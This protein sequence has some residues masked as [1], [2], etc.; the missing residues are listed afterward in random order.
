MQNQSRRLKRK[1]THGFLLKRQ[2]P[3]CQRILV[4]TKDRS[5]W[6]QCQD[7]KTGDIEQTWKPRWTTPGRFRHFAICC[8]EGRSCLMVRTTRNC[9]HHREGATTREKQQRSWL[10]R[11]EACENMVAMVPHQHFLSPREREMR[12]REH[13]C[14]YFG[15]QPATPWTRR[16]W[17]NGCICQRRL[18]WGTE[19]YR[20]P[21]AHST[22][23]RTIEE[24][25]VWRG[26]W[27]HHWCS[28][29]GPSWEI[30][31]SGIRAGDHLHEAA[32]RH[33]KSSLEEVH[34]ELHQKPQ[35]DTTQYQS[36]RFQQ[37]GVYAGQNFVANASPT[38]ESRCCQDGKW[39]HNI[40]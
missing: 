15:F 16:T 17:R 2:P 11:P 20:C 14:T 24:R 8:S 36:E 25:T 18:I 1:N 39:C 33:W 35:R 29:C 9:L 37:G 22:G 26:P 13:D 6:T 40:K 30:Q 19:R 31:F 10:C 28:G 34:L 7:E 12:L 23:S 5:G 38:K 27:L 3:A 32:Q 21:C 4:A